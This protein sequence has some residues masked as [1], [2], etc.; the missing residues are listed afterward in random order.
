MAARVRTSTTVEI[1]A[2]EMTF[3]PD[4][5]LHTLRAKTLTKPKQRVA[6]VS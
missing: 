1:I 3:A 6:A 5:P 2:I 4:K